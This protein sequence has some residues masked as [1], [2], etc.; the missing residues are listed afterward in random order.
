MG[1]ISGVLQTQSLLLWNIKPP[2]KG[3]QSH[4]STGATTPANLRSVQ[5]PPLILLCLIAI[6][7]RCEGSNQS[8]TRLEGVALA[9]EAVQAAVQAAAAA[10]TTDPFVGYYMRD[11]QQAGGLTGQ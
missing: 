6:V 7:A 4:S 5:T 3:C 11:P 10:F 9:E 8:V 2:S 1:I